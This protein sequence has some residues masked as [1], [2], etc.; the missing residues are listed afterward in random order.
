MSLITCET[1]FFHLNP[2]SFMSLDTANQVY[3]ISV[4]KEQ[5]FSPKSRIKF[6]EICSHIDKTIF[7]PFFKNS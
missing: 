6:M 3:L 5:F 2:S 7:F 1:E 4:A